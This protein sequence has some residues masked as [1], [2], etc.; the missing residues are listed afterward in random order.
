[1]GVAGRLQE[2]S[3]VAAGAPC[4]AG[5][6]LRGI[7][8]GAPDLKACVERLVRGGN[9]GVFS[10]PV[11][12]VL[13]GLA[14]GWVWGEGEGRGGA[15]KGGRKRGKGVT[16]GSERGSQGEEEEGENEEKEREK[17]EKEAKRKGDKEDRKAHT[18]EGESVLEP[19]DCATYEEL[20]GTEKAPQEEKVSKGEAWKGEGGREA[21]P[22]GERSEDHAGDGEGD[23]EALPAGGEGEARAGEGEGGW[24]ALPTGGGALGESGRSRAG[25]R[26]HPGGAEGERGRW[27]QRQR[28]GK[29]TPR[30]DPGCSFLGSFLEAL[31]GGRDHC[32]PPAP[33]EGIPLGPTSE[34][35]DQ[36]PACPP[37][38]AHWPRKLSPTR[39]LTT[40]RL[41]S[42][43][44]APKGAQ[45]L[46][47]VARGWQQGKLWHQLWHQL[48]GEG[49]GKRG[50]GR[51]GWTRRGKEG[52]GRRG[53]GGGPKGGGE[54]R[55]VGQ[56]PEVGN[57]ILTVHV[58]R[59][60]VFRRVQE[61]HEVR[62]G[63]A[64]SAT[65][66]GCLT[67]PQI[68]QCIPVCLLSLSVSLSK[69]PLT[70][71]AP[72]GAPRGAPWGANRVRGSLAA[73]PYPWCALGVPCA[74]PCAGQSPALWPL[75]R[76]FFLHTLVAPLP[77]PKRR[78]WGTPLKGEG[79]RGGEWGEGGRGEGRRRGGGRAGGC[80]GR[81]G[82]RTEASDG[83][84]EAAA[85][86]AAH[87][88]HPQ[89]AR[90]A[91]GERGEPGTLPLLLPKVRIVLYC[92][93]LYCTV[94][95]CTVLY[96][97]LVVR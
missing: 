10:R 95:Y 94:L 62:Q 50:R 66:A 72:Q 29:S 23:R 60:V 31:P 93:V 90:H 34:G 11:G 77:L 44:G 46:S 39:S 24:E 83:E 27:N 80:G 6:R 36:L 9:W 58:F 81:W 17:R 33:P 79:E 78:L 47:L 19:A 13:M 20:E 63:K 86:Q 5:T 16:W 45:W 32:E 48:R 52:A 97:P 76:G 25:T 42:Y 38:D 56:W 35:K 67:G 21:L 70:L 96:C 88:P 15:G 12:G 84:N 73:H 1:V 74:S 55:S 41:L 8:A 68:C 2:A 43:L 71:F 85:V 51:R 87:V 4:G 26:G 7:F 3:W 61:S 69:E 82:F 18:G 22:A 57:A 59:D 28:P 30:P 49:R 53:E 37:S 91:R 92:T 54:K 89:W 65:D 75:F 40:S 14:V 64:F